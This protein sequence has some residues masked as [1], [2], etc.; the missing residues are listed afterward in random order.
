M[1]L[2]ATKTNITNKNWHQN[3]FILLQIVCLNLADK[4]IFYF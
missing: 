3:E 2:R 4:S 1:S